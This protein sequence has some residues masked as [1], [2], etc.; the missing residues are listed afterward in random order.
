MAATPSKT[1]N[2]D[3]D[4]PTTT[5]LAFVPPTWAEVVSRVI[6]D[7]DRRKRN[8]IVSGLP[9]HS[10]KEDVDTFINICESHLATKPYV[11]SNR[12][13]RLGNLDKEKTTPRKL[14]IQFDSEMH[15]QDVLSQ[16]RLL[17][18]SDDPFVAGKIFINADLSPEQAKIA[19]EERQKRRQRKL[20]RGSLDPTV[21]PFQA[22]SEP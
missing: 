16:A 19:F 17:R 12:C 18:R 14:L 9:E 5:T 7:T 10:V 6:S 3:L 13:R 11:T 1:T 15:A 20:A 21:P 2:R 4:P 8:I 22:V